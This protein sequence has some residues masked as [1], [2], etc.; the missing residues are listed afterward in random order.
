MI[1]QKSFEITDDKFERELFGNF[2]ENIKI[3]EKSL[4]V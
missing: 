1:V 2:D 4:N 3:I